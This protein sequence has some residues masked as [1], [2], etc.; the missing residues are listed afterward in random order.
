M[1]HVFVV[2]TVPLAM[3]AGCVD[4]D[5][6]PACIPGDDLVSQWL[7]G[8]QEQLFRGITEAGSGGG[9]HLGDT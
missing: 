6:S 5:P 4:A 3:E 2:C 8:G 1:T 9:E 7:P